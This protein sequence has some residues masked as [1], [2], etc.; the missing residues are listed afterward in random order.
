MGE[1]VER[2]VVGRSLV[3]AL[4]TVFIVVLAGVVGAFSYYIVA[5]NNTIASLDTENSQL[6]ANVTSLQKQVASFN[7]SINSLTVNITN[8]Q[9]EL[10][11]ILNWSSSIE[12]MVLSD[13][14]VWVNRTVMVEGNL[15]GPYA[16]PAFERIPWWYQI[17]SGNQTIGVDFSS[18]FSLLAS[19]NASS[20]FWDQFVSNG[21][22]ALIRIYGVV[23]QGEITFSLPELPPE[24]TYYI[25]AETG[26]PL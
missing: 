16:V 11:T 2:K 21:G 8:L 5:K 9:E 4:G 12:D 19:V 17:S 25:E 3:I 13:P 6:D 14:S 7:S 15:T 10:N 20:I 22:S 26:E 1:K 18:N 23:E 24:V